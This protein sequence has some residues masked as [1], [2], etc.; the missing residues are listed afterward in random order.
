[1]SLA[2]HLSRGNL[3]QTDLALM[4][5]FDGLGLANGV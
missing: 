3:S 2:Y 5:A 4:M 1:M